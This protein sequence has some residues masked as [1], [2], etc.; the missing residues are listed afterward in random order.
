MLLF[1]MLKKC[2]NACTLQYAGDDLENATYNAYN[3]SKRFRVASYILNQEQVENI[4]SAQM[5]K[6]HDWIQ[7]KCV[8]ELALSLPLNFKKY[9]H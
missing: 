5:D 6:I 8:G 3:L 9:L 2:T 7:E 1:I 4:F